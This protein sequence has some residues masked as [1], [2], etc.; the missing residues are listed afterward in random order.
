M[1]NAYGCKHKH[2]SIESQPFFVLS[3]CFPFLLVTGFLTVV[4][5]QLSSLFFASVQDELD[6][7]ELEAKN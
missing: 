7:I 1:L 5:H 2:F 6:L 3:F 4:F